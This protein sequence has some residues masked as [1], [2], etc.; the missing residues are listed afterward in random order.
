[1]FSAW[2]RSFRTMSLHSH[3]FS[4]TEQWPFALL[5]WR[6]YT[7]HTYLTFFFFRLVEQQL[8]SLHWLSR[9]N[10]S[11]AWIV[12]TKDEHRERESKEERFI[13][14]IRRPRFPSVRWRTLNEDFRNIIVICRIIRICHLRTREHMCACDTNLRLN[15]SMMMNPINCCRWCRRCVS[16]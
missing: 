1:M 5:I 14:T 6:M 10:C 11:S 2:Q 4:L 16:K 15:V 13:L 12:R 8:S 3:S 9:L 7:R